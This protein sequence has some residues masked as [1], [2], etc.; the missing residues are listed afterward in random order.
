L[1]RDGFGCPTLFV[2]L[3]IFAS[4][5]KEF[6]ESFAGYFSCAS[7]QYPLADLPFLDGRKVAQELGQEI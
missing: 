6:S 7:P 4:S 1:G 2:C 3:S 5:L